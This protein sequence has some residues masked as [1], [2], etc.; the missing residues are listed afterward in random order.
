M[1]FLA[2][3]R[4]CNHCDDLYDPD[5]LDEA[6]DCRDCAAYDPRDHDCCDGTGCRICDKGYYG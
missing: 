2:D 3:K 1:S 5:M 6:G 4:A